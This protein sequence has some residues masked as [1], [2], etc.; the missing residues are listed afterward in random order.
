MLTRFL[1]L[2]ALFAVTLPG[3]GF[4]CDKTQTFCKNGS[5][6]DEPVLAAMR[7]SP[8]E[9]ASTLSSYDFTAVSACDFDPDSGVLKVQYA[10]N[11]QQLDMQVRGFSADPRVYDCRQAPNNNDAA[12]HVGDL[13]E[14]CMI[15]AKVARPGTTGSDLYAM[16]RATTATKRFAYDGACSID[17]RNATGTLQGAFNCT[18]MAQTT[19]GG[20]PRNPVAADNVRADARA[21]FSGDFS[22]PLSQKPLASSGTVTPPPP[23]PPDANIA[24]AAS[25]GGTATAGLTSTG[26]CTLDSQTGLF[27]ASFAKNEQTMELEIRNFDG[28]KAAHTCLQAANNAVDSASAGDLYESCM[29]ETRLTH[30]TPGARVTDGYSTHRRAASVKIFTY[31]GACTLATEESGGEVRGTVNCAGMAQTFY[32]G[33]AR[34][35]VATDGVHPDVTGALTGDFK[36]KLIRK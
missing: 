26:A 12:T 24:L 31:D 34:N 20:L 11:G 13:F 2:L 35:P 5:G 29:V 3:C 32:H 36:C 30:G 4:V 6:D 16:H 15:E 14:T 27:K 7:M 33:L 10:Q 28:A 22:C 21:T 9:P 1:A 25:D 18:E 23:P 19:Y 8:S 17:V